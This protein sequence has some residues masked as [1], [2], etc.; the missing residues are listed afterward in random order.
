MLVLV[1]WPL[2]SMLL[3]V[4]KG[5]LATNGLINLNNAT[6]LFVLLLVGLLKLLV[7]MAHVLR[8]YRLILTSS[9]IQ[10]LPTRSLNLTARIWMNMALP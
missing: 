8:F 10:K 7:L 5:L 6:P 1:R 3:M 4:I 2:K 9:I